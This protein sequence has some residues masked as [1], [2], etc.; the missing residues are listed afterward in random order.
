MVCNLHGQTGR[1]T[2]WVNGKNN[3]EMANFHLNDRVYMT[4]VYKS[5]PFTEKRPRT[6]E[7]GIF[8]CGRSRDHAIVTITARVRNNGNLNFE[9]SCY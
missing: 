2:V 1:F 9:F 5:L 4:I 8:L 7:T 3:S 6:P